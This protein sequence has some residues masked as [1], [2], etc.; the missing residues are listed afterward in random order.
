MMAR[1]TV[2]VKLTEVEPV[3]RLITAVGDAITD[4]R[5]EHRP[6]RYDDKPVTDENAVGCAACYPGDSSWPC[7]SRMVADELLEAASACRSSR[8]DAG[9]RKAPGAERSPL[10]V[11]PSPR[12]SDGDR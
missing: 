5:D 4:L 8:G 7:A 10:G 1:A 3:K 2:A 6:M 9:G 12:T 11:K